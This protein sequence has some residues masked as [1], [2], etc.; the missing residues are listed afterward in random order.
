MSFGTKVPGAVTPRSR[1]PWRIM[2]ALIKCDYTATVEPASDS[3][4]TEI[5]GI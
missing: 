1:L 5:R 4:T 2:D 3:E